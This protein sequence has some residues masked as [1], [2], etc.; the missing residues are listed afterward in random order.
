MQS[1]QFTIRVYGLWIDTN[2]NILLSDEH[3]GD[4][5]F[6][7]FPGGGLE[8]GEGLRDG[9]KREWKEELGIAIEVLDHIYTT[10]FFQASAFHPQTQVI[11]VYYSVAPLEKPML[12]FKTK[13]FDFTRNQHQD[14]VFR[15]AG[16]KHLQPKDL[17]FPIDQYVLKLLQENIKKQEILMQSRD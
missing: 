12:N 15:W 10:D 6:T 7:K 17:N 16:I 9:L 13:P 4:F 5:Q 14:E 8:W 1:Q 11:S 2:H 3:I